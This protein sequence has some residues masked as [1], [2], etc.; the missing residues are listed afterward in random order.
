[1]IGTGA[2]FVIFY[3]LIS[4]V[5]PARTFVVTY[6]APAFAVVYGATLLDEPIDPETIAGLVLILSGCWLA[7]EGRLPGDRR[8]REAREA[9]PGSPEPAPTPDRSPHSIGPSGQLKPSRIAVSMSSS[10]AT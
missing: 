1:M 7:A 9:L 3:W 2:A 6:I 5:G 10:D 8:R 4:T